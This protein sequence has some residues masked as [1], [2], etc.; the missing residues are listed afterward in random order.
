MKNK[1]CQIR[2]KNSSLME[3]VTE[4]KKCFQSTKSPWCSP[5]TKNLLE[6]SH[7]ILDP[8]G[9]IFCVWFKCLNCTLL[10]LYFWILSSVNVLCPFKVFF[11][12]RL[13]TSIT[14]NTPGARLVQMNYSQASIHERKMKKA[15][16][17][18]SAGMRALSPQGDGLP[19]RACLPVQG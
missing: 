13:T 4:R 1:S 9:G 17:D 5:R 10:T 19:C 11:F 18:R 6:L 8:P 14:R 3:C 16:R 2:Q 15:L 12:F 7:F